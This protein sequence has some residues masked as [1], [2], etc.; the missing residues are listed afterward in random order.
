MNKLR[1]ISLLIS[2]SIILIGFLLIAGISF[3]QDDAVMKFEGK[4]KDENG[5][6]L[7]GASVSIMQNGKEVYSGTTDANGGFKSYEGYYG[8]LYKVVVTKA[9]HTKNTIEVDSRNY[10][11]DLLK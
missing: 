9:N 10:D 6:P 8:Y 7:S 1:N 2:K 4:I 3:G 11:D 5:R